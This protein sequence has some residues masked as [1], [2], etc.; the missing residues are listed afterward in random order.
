MTDTRAAVQADYWDD[1]TIGRFEWSDLGL[2]PRHVEVRAEVP[3]SRTYGRL[4]RKG[5]RYWPTMVRV[6]LGFVRD[7][8][9]M[10]STL[11]PDDARTFAAALISAA[12]LA[13]ATD[14]PDSDACGHWAP[15]SCGAA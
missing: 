8:E 5:N 11:L 3:I 6:D 15:C 14:K 1:E 4:P 13:D 7:G 10:T 12:E 9:P 2:D